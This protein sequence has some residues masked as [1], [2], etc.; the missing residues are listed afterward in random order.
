MPS[1][2]VTIHCHNE[3]TARRISSIVEERF[4]PEGI[5]IA[6]FE[7]MSGPGWTIDLYFEDEPSES[8]LQSIQDDLAPVEDQWTIKTKELPDAD[9]VAEGLAGLGAV[10][11][12]RFVVHGV[13]A[14]NSLRTHDI[15]LQVEASHAFGTGHH[16]TTAGCLEAIAWLTARTRPVNALDLGCGTA[17]LAIALAKTSKCPVLATD[18]DRTSVRISRENVRQNNTVPYIRCIEANGFEHPAFR[19]RKPFDLII[20]NILA[21]P[22]IDLAK[23]V[24]DHLSYDGHVILSGLL[25]RQEKWVLNRYRKEG[26]IPLR[27][28][29]NEGWSTLVLKRVR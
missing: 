8:F 9:W 4:L 24:S 25:V 22:L 27:V 12:G 11:V 14:R 10:R 23:D 1:Y 26:L 17:V 21:G 3:T 7:N 29:R 20:A 6:T 16:G 19:N 28:T 18:I 13:H 15:S 5:P 2:Q